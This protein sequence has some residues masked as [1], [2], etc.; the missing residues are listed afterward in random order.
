[1]ICDY[2][3]VDEKMP[4]YDDMREYEV[5]IGD[6]VRRVRRI[7]NRSAYFSPGTL[8]FVDCTHTAQNMLVDESSVWAWRQ[9][10]AV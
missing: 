7:G 1:M 2:W 8:V 5:M 9:L 6:D 4:R 10:E 3:E